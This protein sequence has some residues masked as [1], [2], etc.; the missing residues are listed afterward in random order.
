MDVDYPRT[1]SDTEQTITTI[2]ADFEGADAEVR[3]VG[4]RPPEELATRVHAAVKNTILSLL[5][6]RVL[7]WKQTDDGNWLLI[8]R[9][10]MPEKPIVTEGGG[11]KWVP[12]YRTAEEFE[13]Q[14]GSGNGLYGNLPRDWAYELEREGTY[15]FFE[16]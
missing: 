14:D 16:E 4:E 15:V 6:E 10:G 2:T 12:P 1:M 13:G 5:D 11:V 9:D 8:F 3:V 7:I